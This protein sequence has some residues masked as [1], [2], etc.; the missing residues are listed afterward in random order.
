MKMVGKSMKVM[1]INC[2]NNDA[3]KRG[4]RA[5]SGYDYSIMLANHIMDN[6]Y[7]LVGTQ[8][9]SISFTERL[10]SI[11]PNYVFS[12]KY[13]NEFKLLRKLYPKMK[14]LSENN[15]ILVKGQPIVEKTFSLPW[16]PHN[17]KDLW[18]ALKRKSIMRRIASGVLVKVDGNDIYMLNTHLDYA[19][20]SVQQRQLNKIYQFLATKSKKYP[21]ILTGDF[22][23][24]VDDEIFANFIDKLKKIGIERVPINDKTNAKKYRN[25]SAIDHIFLSNSFNIINYGIVDDDNIKEITDHLAIYVEVVEKENIC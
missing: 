7:D 17:F 1:S 23:L 15:N 16:M 22:N 13:R 24:E 18:H 8:E 25:K 14:G 4:G 2:Q 6:E 19:T 5:S 12:G 21:I 11:L 9:M 20:K 10:K 3:N